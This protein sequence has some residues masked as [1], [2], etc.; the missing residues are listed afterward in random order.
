MERRENSVG[1]RVEM[2]MFRTILTFLKNSFRF[3][4]TTHGSEIIA[5]QKYYLSL[6]IN[7]TYTSAH[8]IIDTKS[9]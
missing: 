4:V 2:P 3:P 1:Y 9:F 8:F 7:D 5:K 6:C